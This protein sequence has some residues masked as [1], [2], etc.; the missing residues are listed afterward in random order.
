MFYS[1]FLLDA[2]TYKTCTGCPSV[3][4][5]DK[6]TENNKLAQVQCAFR[7]GNSD[8]LAAEKSIRFGTS[9]ANIVSMHVLLHLCMQYDMFVIPC[10][11]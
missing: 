8:E 7:T 3:V 10:F 5:M 4:H 11:A 1:E 9:P 2:F 6:G